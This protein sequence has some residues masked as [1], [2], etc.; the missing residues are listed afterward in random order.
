MRG[1]NEPCLCGSGKK[2][3]KC[4]LGKEKMR[5]ASVKFEPP[6]L[7]E[8]NEIQTY[9]ASQRAADLQW[10]KRYG[11]IRP[12]VSTD[13]AG[14]KFVAGGSRMYHSGERPW[15]YVTDFLMDYL[16]LLF[17]K[18][19]WMN[20]FRRPEADQHPVVRWKTEAARHMNNQPLQ[21]SGFRITAATGFMA[22]YMNLAFNLFAIEDNSRFDEDLLGRLKSKEQFQSARHEVFAEATCLR[23]GFAIEHENEKDRKTRHAEFTARHKRTGQLLSVEAK[24]RHQRGI[25][26]EPGPIQPDRLNI[27]FGDLLNDAIAKNAPH[28]LVVFI[29]MNLPPRAAEKVLGADPHHPPNPSRIATAILDANR[30]THGGD[31]KYALLVL[32]NHPHHYAETQEL[33]PKKQTLEV[34]PMAPSPAVAHPFALHE[35]RKGVSLYGKIPQEFPQRLSGSH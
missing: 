15:N 1:R 24:S 13:F 32:T 4:C 12:F 17:G 16:P 8:I 9:F 11:C 22:A 18:E 20:E 5:P 14:R 19:W 3:K 28:P 34:M 30:K 25:L 6:S 10:I 31:D 33:D 7:D 26:G 35:L 29:D 27:R 23:A 2:Y 21:P